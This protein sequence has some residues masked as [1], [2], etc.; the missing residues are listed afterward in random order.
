MLGIFVPMF[1]REIAPAGVAGG[2]ESLVRFYSNWPINIV[3]VFPGWY[4][5]WL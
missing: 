4:N 5:V 3:G 2:R 1:L